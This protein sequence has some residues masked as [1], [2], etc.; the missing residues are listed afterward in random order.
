M[1]RRPGESHS[2]LAVHCLAESPPGHA[3]RAGPGLSLVLPIAM[4]AGALSTCG[5]Q[6]ANRSLIGFEPGHAYS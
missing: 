3:R 5:G 2:D 4:V 6:A 1:E